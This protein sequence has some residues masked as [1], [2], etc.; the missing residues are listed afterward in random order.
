MDQ[1]NGQ[2]HKQTAERME[3]NPDHLSTYCPQGHTVNISN[4]YDA[5]SGDPFLTCLL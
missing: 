1:E 3:R 5:L 2:K 4:Y